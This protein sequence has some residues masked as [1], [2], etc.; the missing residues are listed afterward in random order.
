MHVGLSGAQDKDLAP[1]NRALALDRRTPGPFDPFG[2]AHVTFR[3]AHN[4][5]ALGWLHRLSLFARNV[6]RFRGRLVTTS[7]RGMK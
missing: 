5:I 3:F 4:A 1:A 7:E 6:A 2:I